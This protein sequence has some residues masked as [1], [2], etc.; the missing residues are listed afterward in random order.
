MKGDIVKKYAIVL[1]CSIMLSMGSVYGF[2]PVE[3]VYSRK[4]PKTTADE[5]REL[6]YWLTV[7]T[8]ENDLLKKVQLT[9]SSDQLNNLLNELQKLENQKNSQALYTY[10]A[11][12][13]VTVID[14]LWYASLRRLP[15][16]YVLALIKG[17]TPV[18][19]AMKLLQEQQEL[20]KKVS[21][22]PSVEGTN[23]SSTSERPQGPV[24]ESGQPVQTAEGGLE[25]GDIEDTAL[26]GE[27]GGKGEEKGG[28]SELQEKSEVEQPVGV[29]PSIEDLKKQQ[30][31]LQNAII[32]D[33]GDVNKGLDVY[34]TLG[35]LVNECLKQSV[36]SID[37][38]LFLMN[39]TQEL[40]LLTVRQ[41]GK[42]GDIGAGGT[43]EDYMKVY[44]G[45]DKEQ[46]NQILER[47]WDTS[48]KS[49]AT[50]FAAWVKHV[51]DVIKTISK[52]VDKEKISERKKDLIAHCIEYVTVTAD[53]KRHYKK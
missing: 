29:A 53:I 4:R 32:T 52:N 15:R 5:I 28:M 18:M 8:L 1:I 16:T 50:Q 31:Q 33:V 13:T 42:H 38:I 11:N 6:E 49:I 2:E 10:L 41:L 30:E 27:E 7:A 3:P 47:M 9:I 44:S 35:E 24:S 48:A 21:S 25:A 12:P 46:F 39:K 17:V 20:L 14:P 51:D 34:I 19:Q 37:D 23:D 43:P 26:S 22:Q 40:P 45:D 36:V